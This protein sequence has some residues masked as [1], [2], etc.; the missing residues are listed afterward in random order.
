LLSTAGN[1]LNQ[2]YFI[3]NIFTRAISIFSDNNLLLQA[4]INFEAY[5]DSTDKLREVIKSLLKNYQMNRQLWNLYVQIEMA[6][7]SI[8]VARK[9]YDTALA[10]LPKLLKIRINLP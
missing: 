7:N 1:K 2:K 10:M 3:Q 4:F 6:N 9:I 8:S 5:Y